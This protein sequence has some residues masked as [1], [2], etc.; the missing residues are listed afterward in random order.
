MLAIHPFKISAIVYNTAVVFSAASTLSNDFTTDTAG[1]LTAH[2]IT[3]SN[4]AS[5]S[6]TDTTEGRP[7]AS[8]LV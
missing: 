2:P 5:T 6:V 4:A 1:T 3:S 7:Q 8:H